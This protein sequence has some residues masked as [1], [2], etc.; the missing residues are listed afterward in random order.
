MPRAELPPFD[1][2]GDGSRLLPCVSIADLRGEGLAALGAFMRAY[3]RKDSEGM[4]TSGVALVSHLLPDLTDEDLGRLMLAPE[5]L[6]ALIQHAQPQ[7]GKQISP[8]STN[9]NQR[10][11]RWN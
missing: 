3:T 4:T 7:T 2:L 11:K 9:P 5:R 8:P 1:L 10:D 6:T